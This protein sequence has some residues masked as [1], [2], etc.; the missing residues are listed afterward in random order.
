MFLD[1]SCK[2][3]YWLSIS[4]IKHMIHLMASHFVS[5]LNISRL[6]DT[7]KWIHSGNCEDLEDGE[8]N[9]DI[10]TNMEV[11]ASVLRSG[12]SFPLPHA[13]LSYDSCLSWPCTCFSH[14][15][16][17]WLM[18]LMTVHLSPTLI[19]PMTLI[20]HTYLSSDSCLSW[21]CTS[22]HTYSIMTHTCPYLRNI[23]IDLGTRCKY[24]T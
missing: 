17:L 23:Y 5:A 14:L 6:R 8:D 12:P 3:L 16:S 22:S 24:P 20:S 2:W 21:P 7:Q 4:C 10:D 18:S 9:L 19:F 13:Y 1:V 11:E 15:S